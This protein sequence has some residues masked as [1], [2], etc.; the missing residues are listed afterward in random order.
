MQNAV[1]QLTTSLTSCNLF[2]LGATRRMMC[3]AKDRAS[4]KQASGTAGIDTQI[5]PYKK[6]SE[7]VLNAVVRQCSKWHG[8][9]ARM[10]KSA[11]TRQELKKGTKQGENIAVV[12]REKSTA[13]VELQDK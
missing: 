9:A 5:E 3:P 7:Q 4:L 8:L 10:T 1:H 12:K 2:A 13:G 11:G 6:G